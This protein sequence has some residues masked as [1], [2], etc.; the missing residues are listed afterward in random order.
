MLLQFGDI[1]PHR[2]EVC[3]LL[4]THSTGSLSGSLLNENARSG[5]RSP[6][7]KVNLADFSI[8]VIAVDLPL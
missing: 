5:G 6:V 2:I 4:R 3:Y 8:D 7:G 1:L